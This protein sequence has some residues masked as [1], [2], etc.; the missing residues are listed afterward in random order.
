MQ[1]VNR[2]QVGTSEAD[3]ALAIA[4]VQRLADEA[5]SLRKLF[6][7]LSRR[8]NAGNRA[9]NDAPGDAADASE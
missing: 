8:D 7:A 1:E 9:V 5:G 3:R 2:L 6:D 4:A